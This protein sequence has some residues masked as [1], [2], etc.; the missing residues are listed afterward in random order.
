MN[1]EEL[2]KL[3]NS[4]KELDKEIEIR[5]KNNL[6]KNKEFI[7]SRRY[8]L[9]NKKSRAENHFKNLYVIA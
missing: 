9:L 7:N 6:A 5:L 4:A 8:K 3:R 1:K 2:I